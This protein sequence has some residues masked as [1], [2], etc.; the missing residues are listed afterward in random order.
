MHQT[1]KGTPWYFRMKAHRGVDRQTNLIHSG[2][3]TAATVHDSQVWP[4]WL[5][6]QEPRVG[7]DAASSG[8]RDVSQQH[9]PRATS[10][11]QPQAH[12]QRPLSE[13]ERARNRTK[14]K[15]RANVAQAC[16]VST[17]ILGWAQVLDRGLA[18]NT[19]WLPISGGLANPLWRGGAWWRESSGGVCE[20]GSGQPDSGRTP[21][22]TLPDH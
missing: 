9:A 19:P 11:G 18:K 3:A 14:S 4:Q 8:Q 13:R 21:R 22:T 5:S 15:V 16:L 1:Q 17:R 6:G 20:R 7:G 12:R 10:F 2:A